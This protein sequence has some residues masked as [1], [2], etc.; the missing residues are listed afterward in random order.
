[1][2]RKSK[3]GSS[4]GIDCT[5]ASE[6]KADYAANHPL[7]GEEDDSDIINPPEDEA[8]P[9]PVPP[10]PPVNPFPPIPAPAPAPPAPPA[11]EATPI[12]GEDGEEMSPEMKIEASEE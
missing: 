10:P 3:E 12:P 8:P 9:T 6:Q 4:S 5:K 7:P 2:T 11:A 1:M